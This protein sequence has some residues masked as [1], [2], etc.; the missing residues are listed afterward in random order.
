VI[1]KV[2][3]VTGAS[4]GIGRATALALARDGMQIVATARNL[5]EL[6]SLNK[7]IIIAGGECLVYPADLTREDDLESLLDVVHTAQLQIDLLVHSAGLARVGKIENMPYTDWQNVLTMNLSVPF[8]LTQKSL[9]MINDGGHVIFINSVAGK[10][11]FSEWS[12]YCAAKHGLRALAE[13]LRQEVAARKIK[14]TSIYPASVDTA[15][16]N[17]LPYSWDRS[18]MLTPGIV[19][20]AILTCYRQAG[21]VVI[22]NLEIENTAGVF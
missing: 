10:S 12:A 8:H 9:P 20:D 22:K 4:K 1:P 15:L 13:V 2:A 11:S 18:K 19:A 6:E 14:V 16:H 3:L 17:N 21:D 7:E 5:K